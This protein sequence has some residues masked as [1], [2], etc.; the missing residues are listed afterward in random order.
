M[1]TEI[2][3]EEIIDMIGLDVKSK[4]ML[5]LGA[6]LKAQENPTDFI[7]FESLREQQIGRAHV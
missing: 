2:Q 1:T 5:V 4:D 3:H 6:L 7:D